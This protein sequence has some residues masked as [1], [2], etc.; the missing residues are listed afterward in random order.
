MPYSQEG[1]ERVLEN[2]VIKV[3][4][5]DQEGQDVGMSFSFWTIACLLSRIRSPADVVERSSLVDKEL[6]QFPR[7]HIHGVVADSQVECGVDDSLPVWLE[8]FLVELL[9]RIACLLY[10]VYLATYA[11]DADDIQRDLAGPSSEFEHSR[12]L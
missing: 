4:G 10:V 11:G 1:E 6:I 9:K 5:L 7:K 2:L 3:V 12:A 8:Q